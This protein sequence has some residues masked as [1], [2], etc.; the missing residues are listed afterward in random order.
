M[1]CQHIGR[2]KSEDKKYIV[3]STLTTFSC[4]INY[5]STS[6]F[7]TNSK[8]Y[9]SHTSCINV[10][11]LYPNQWQTLMA[12]QLYDYL[13]FLPTNLLSTKWQ[14]SRLFGNRLVFVDTF[15]ER[16]VN[17]QMMQNV[18]HIFRFEIAFLHRNFIACI[19]MAKSFRPI[20]T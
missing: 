2:R 16:V 20:C 1:N 10:S 14:I 9:S 6:K 7:Q 19:I 13:Y 3:L 4:T 18:H 12:Y 17:R 8:S 5:W 15:W 11:S